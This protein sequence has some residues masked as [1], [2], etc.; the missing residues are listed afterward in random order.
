M[1]QAWV[2]QGFVELSGVQLVNSCPEAIQAA[3]LP[4]QS[5]PLKQRVHS[6]G[7]AGSL[8]HSKTC[9]ATVQ[10]QRG[11]KYSQISLKRTDTG[12][13]LSPLSVGMSLKRMTTSKLIA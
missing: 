3:R 13:L 2:C 9:K 6:R 1:A 4:Y 10:E 8:L 11:C 5:P 7:Q 12:A